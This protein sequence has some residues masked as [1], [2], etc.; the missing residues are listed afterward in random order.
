MNN[1][2]LHLLDR[3]KN[4]NV[5]LIKNM[6]PDVMV[7]MTDRFNESLVRNVLYVGKTNGEQREI[8]NYI[9][10]K[11]KHWKKGTDML[12]GMLANPET[13]PDFI[14]ELQMDIECGMVVTVEGSVSESQA[15]P[16]V[17]PPILGE[18][19]R[20]LKGLSETV[21]D[22]NTPNLRAIIVEKD[23]RIEKLEAE[24]EELKQKIAQTDGDDNQVWI[25]WLDWDVFHPSIKV[26]EVYKTIEQ[27]ATPELGDKA[28]CY[29]LFRVLKEIKWLKKG[30]ANKDVLKWWSAHFGCEW[31]SDNQLKFTTLP[32]A[33]TKATTTNQWK[34]CGGKNNE[35]YYNY[36]QDLK[37]A[38]AWNKGQGQYETRT[39]FVKA[40]CLPPEK[41]K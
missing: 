2:H 14:L 23:K 36:A 30:A 7:M 10:D 35:Y 21:A 18:S 4:L 3:I 5:S 31:H 12:W 34:N 33:I 16:F 6:S 41:C 40:G 39:Q 15:K 25:D 9:K 1:N 26:E 32:D 38:F 8:I 29:A 37:K 17:M 22:D 28:K 20:Q 24:V 19:L 13:Y 11:Y 27:K